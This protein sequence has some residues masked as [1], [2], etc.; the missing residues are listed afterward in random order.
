L[1]NPPDAHPQYFQTGILKV[2]NGAEG[3][4]TGVYDSSFLDVLQKAAWQ[5][6][7]RAGSIRLSNQELAT[8]AYRPLRGYAA[9][10]EIQVGARMPL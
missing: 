3:Y 6:L 8:G 4:E 1:K 10:C 2:S 9:C 7:F 5:K